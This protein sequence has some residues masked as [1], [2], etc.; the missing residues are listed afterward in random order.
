M[1]ISSLPIYNYAVA[2]EELASKAM[3]QY[4]TCCGKSIC[5][6]CVYS[7]CESGNN[8]KC[9]FCNSNSNKTAEKSIE[10]IT[11]RVEANDAGAI[12]QLGNNYHHGHQLGFQQDREKAK[13]LLMRAAE[14]GSSQA[15]FNLSIIYDEEQDSKKAK[16]HY[17]AALWQDTKM[18]E[19]TLDTLRE[20]QETW[21]DI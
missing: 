8:E 18:Q 13:E 10:D 19:T 14:L 5:G 16:F 4:Y 11:K 15:H 7:F 3:K 12:F 1:T 6:G 2:N 17:Q 9:P 21:N 20:N